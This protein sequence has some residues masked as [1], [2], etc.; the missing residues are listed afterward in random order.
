LSKMQD[1]LIIPNSDRV[2]TLTPDNP[3]IH[4]AMKES[5]NEKYLFVVS[6]SRAAE[7]AALSIAGLQSADGVDMHDPS[8]KVSIRNGKVLLQLPPLGTRLYKLSNIR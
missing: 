5:G 1:V 2:L 6:D 4:G 8:K 3:A 7:E